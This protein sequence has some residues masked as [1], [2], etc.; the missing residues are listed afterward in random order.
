MLYESELRFL[1]ETLK[2]FRIGVKFTSQENLFGDMFDDTIRTV[3]GSDL[4]YGEAMSELHFR[5][6]PFIIYKFS[7]SLKLCFMMLLLPDT[8]P[9]RIMVVGPYLSQ[10]V[11]STDILELSE[12][13][14]IDKDRQK[15]FSECYRHL[16]VVSEHDRVYSIMETFGECIWGGASGFSFEDI[17]REL[18]THDE[19]LS[20]KRSLT[21]ADSLLVDME[22]MKKRY[23]FENELIRAVSLGQEHR[24]LQTLSFL[25]ENSFEARTNDPIRN[26][27]NYCVIMNTLLRKAAENGGVHPLYINDVSSSFAVRIEQLS[28]MKALTE[29]MQEMF[30]TYCRLVRKHSMRNFSPSVQ[31]VI[32]IINSDLSANLSLHALAESQNISPGYLSTIF[33]KET[34]KTI[35]EYV[36]QERMKLAGRLL[37]TTSL[38]IQSVALYCGIM[39][40]QYFSKLFKKHTGKTPK[41]YREVAK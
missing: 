12:K 7:N 41:E 29:L 19:P 10:P 39:D 3:F 8:H 38:Q 15:A 23:D 2:K 14:G 5:I 1:C 22:L 18:Y 40:V 9:E 32:A 16:T 25:A 13:Y 26:I 31:K 11:G 24:A 37:T 21:D 28:S 20:K 34:G 36:L 35:T 4:G 6:K 30:T 17:N 27:K 33:K